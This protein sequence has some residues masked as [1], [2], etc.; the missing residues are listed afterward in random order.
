MSVHVISTRLRFEMDRRGLSA[1]ELAHAARVSRPTVCA[2]L[3]DRGISS[4]SLQ[5][6]AAALMAIPVIDVLDSLLSGPY[7]GLA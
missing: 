4:R 1:T 7:G 5:R 6:I 2:A 3:D